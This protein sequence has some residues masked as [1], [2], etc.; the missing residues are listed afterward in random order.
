VHLFS[1]LPPTG[2]ALTIWYFCSK[3]KP[4]PCPLPLPS[5]PCPYPL[6][7]INYATWDCGTRRKKTRANRSIS[8]L[9]W[10]PHTEAFGNSTQR[11]RKNV[12]SSFVIASVGYFFVRVIVIVPGSVL[13]TQNSQLFLPTN[14]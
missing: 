14:N 11:S 13:V 12:D 2:I 7:L 4:C 5:P 6:P 9:S 1:G 8:W 3:F 10:L